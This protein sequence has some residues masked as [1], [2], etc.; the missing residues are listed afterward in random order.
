MRRP[1]LGSIG[2]YT[3]IAIGIGIGLGALSTSLPTAAWAAENGWVRGEIRLNIRTGAGTQFKIVGV[4]KTGDGVEI[5]QREE[6]WT[7]IRIQGD[8]GKSREGWIPE[9]YLKANPPPTLRLAQAEEEVSRLTTEFKTLAEETQAL[10]EKEAALTTADSA[11]EA[12][13]KELTRENMKLHAG[14]RYPE[15]IT[16]ASILAAGML[17]GSVLY[18]AST[19]RQQTRIRL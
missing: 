1:V 2:L 19:R 7:K 12:R 17:L 15:W 11:Q 10:R 13:I 14:D 9:G 8:A 3:A 18:R 6:G 4:A 5:I 16:G